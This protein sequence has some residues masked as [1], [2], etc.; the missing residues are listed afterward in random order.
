MKLDVA[1]PNICIPRLFTSMF[2]LP[3]SD[4]AAVLEQSPRLAA[5]ERMVGPDAPPKH[6]VVPVLVPAPPKKKFSPPSSL[7]KTTPPASGSLTALRS[8]TVGTTPTELQSKE[9]CTP[10]SG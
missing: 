5:L 3:P 10:P 6:M 4:A 9:S 2:V 7:V 8:C 1:R